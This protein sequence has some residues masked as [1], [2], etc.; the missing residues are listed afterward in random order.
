MRMELY[1]IEIERNSVVVRGHIV[2]PTEARA[3][4]LV[5]EHDDMLGQESTEFTLE[6]VDETL[7]LDRRLGLDDM[8]EGGPVGFASYYDQ[9]GWIVHVTALQRLRLFRIEDKAGTENYVIAPDSN[10]AST[11]YMMNNPVKEGEH[12][13]FRIFDGLADLP[14]ERIANLQTLLE[15]GP[16][17]IAT[18][19]N[20]HGWSVE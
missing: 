12:R 11:I 17:G 5:F 18:F 1:E 15:F 19:Q 14:N 6:R 2:A 13:L 10:F 4:E 7:P 20:E 3:A 9:I 8:L 16:V